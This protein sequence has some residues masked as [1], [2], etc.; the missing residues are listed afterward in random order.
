MNILICTDGSAASVQSA[1]MVALLHFPIQSNITILGVSECDED[2]DILTASMNYID[3]IL[4]NR[5]TVERKIRKGNPTD[6]IMSEALQS[7]YDLVA[8][9]GGGKRLGL[10][11]PQLGSTASKLSRKLHT[12]YLVARNIP[13]SLKQVLFCTSA[14]TTVNQTLKIGGAWLSNTEAQVSLLRVQPNSS[15][16]A[17]DLPLDRGL[18]QLRESGIESEV[19][20][21]I[22]QGMIVQEVVNEVSECNCDL[23][24]VGAHYQPGQDLWQGTLLDDVTDQLLNKTN[25]SVLII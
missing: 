16:A 9:G 15:T 18:Q 22:R 13:E 10:L 6:E 21:R 14:D 12:H 11:H 2:M 23:L 8:V 19:R 5:S 25:C 3:K 17:T 7:E 24:V 4:G 1:E 20:P